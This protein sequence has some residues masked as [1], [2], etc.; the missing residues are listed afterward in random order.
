MASKL[1]QFVLSKRFDALA[2]RGVEKAVEETQAAGLTPAG[3]KRPLK[4]HAR[5]ATVV[6][7][8]A[9]RPI[10]PKRKTPRVA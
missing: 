10:S 9:P 5:R 4:A 3:D 7:I 8:E 6:T 1:T 2:A